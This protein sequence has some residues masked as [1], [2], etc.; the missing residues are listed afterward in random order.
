[1][2]YRLEVL[3]V[4]NFS[5]YEF[6]IVGLYIVEKILY[7]PDCRSMQALEAGDSPAESSM[8]PYAASDWSSGS[9]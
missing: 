1:M 5:F 4:T 2:E 9:K 3:M 8:Q 7:P 6:E